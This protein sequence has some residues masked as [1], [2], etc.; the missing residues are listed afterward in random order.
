VRDS[1]RLRTLKAK[2][3]AQEIYLPQRD[4]R[5]GMKDKDRK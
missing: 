2:F 5:Q 3:S 4:R 1:Y